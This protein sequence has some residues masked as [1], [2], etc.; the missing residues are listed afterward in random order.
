MC[1]KYFLNTNETLFTYFNPG[2]FWKGVSITDPG[3]DMMFRILRIC[4]L[5]RLIKHSL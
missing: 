5:C 1:Q 4:S 2:L 3:V